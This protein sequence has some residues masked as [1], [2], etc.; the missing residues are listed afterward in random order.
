MDERERVLAAIEFRSPDRV[1]IEWWTMDSKI[2]LLKSDIAFVAHSGNSFRKEVEAPPGRLRYMDEWGCIW[3]QSQINPN[4]GQVVVH[5]LAD[6][7]NIKHYEFPATNIEQK[8]IP[9]STQINMIK[10]YGNKFIFGHLGNLLWERLHFLRGMDNLMMD[11]YLNPEVVEFLGDKIIEIHC[12]ELR[13]YKKYGVDGVAFCDDWGTQR[14]LLI[15]PELWRKFFKPRYKNL[16]DEA[17]SLGLK[18]YMHSCGWIFE[19][20]EDLIEIGLDVIQLDQPELF[21]IETLSE[22]YGGRICFCCP[23]DIQRVLISGDIQKIEESAKKM[24]ELLGRFDGGFIARAYP[25]PRDI[26]VDFKSHNAAYEAF[27]KYGKYNMVRRES[28]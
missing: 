4:M 16:F 22:A 17:H 23:V 25:Q 1:P 11:L 7:N 14:A 9:V 18:V 21:G 28:L 20:I 13:L 8:F 27:L 19:I 6:I 3:E 15:S 10:S 2:D 5:P 24:I 26:G 12:K